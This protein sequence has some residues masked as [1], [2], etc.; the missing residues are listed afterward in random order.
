M[1]RTLAVFVSLVALALAAPAHATLPIGA[2]APDFST[3]A[4]LAGSD[5][6]FR[7]ADALKKGPVVLYFYPKAFTQ[8]CTAEAHDFSEAQDAFK[9][10]GATVIGMS[11]DDMATLHKFSIDSKACSGK[12]AI[13]VATQEV[14][15]SYDVAMFPFPITNRTSYVIAPDGSILLTYSDL[16]A[17]LHVTKTLDAVK[18]WKAAHPN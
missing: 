12:F 18:A 9:A 4:T 17:T 10:A 2:K 14:I 11:A 5:F 8:G 16:K 3:Q 1:K 6:S 7:L 15:K 13:G